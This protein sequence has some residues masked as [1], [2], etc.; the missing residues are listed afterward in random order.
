MFANAGFL[1]HKSYSSGFYGYTLGHI[2]T[3]SIA[4]HLGQFDSNEAGTSDIPANNSIGLRH[5]YEFQNTRPMP[6]KRRKRTC[7]FI[8]YFIRIAVSMGIAA[9]SAWC[10]NFVLLFNSIAYYRMAIYCPDDGCHGNK[11]CRRS[12]FNI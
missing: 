8:P 4:F 9:T 1:D 12:K 2:F 7:Y 6:T 10:D 3:L 5:I 11:I